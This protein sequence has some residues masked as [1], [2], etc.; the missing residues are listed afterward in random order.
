MSPHVRSARLAQRVP[1]A[2]A[3]AVGVLNTLCFFLSFSQSFAMKGSTSHDDFKFK[4]SLLGAD[5]APQ[6]WSPTFLWFCPLPLPRPSVTSNWGGGLRRSLPGIGGCPAVCRVQPILSEV[7]GRREKC[8]EPLPTDVTVARGPTFKIS[9]F[10]T[11]GSAFCSEP[12]TNSR[13][14]VIVHTDYRSLVHG[15]QW[16]LASEGSVCKLNQETGFIKER[17]GESPAGWGQ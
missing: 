10:P 12:Q 13:F 9:F 17:R 5:R 14:L 3:Q 6:A 11:P 2:G 7:G 16:G 8:P 1:R 4:V 15:Q